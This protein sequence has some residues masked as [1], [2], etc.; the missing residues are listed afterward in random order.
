MWSQFL[1]Q[2]F[3]FSVNL[4]TALAF[5]SVFWLYFDAWVERKNLKEFLKILGFLLLSLS[6]LVHSTLIESSGFT[7]TVLGSNLGE[8][9]AV[10]LKC[11]GFAFL[12]SGLVYDPLI[13][14][15]KISAVFI[16]S[17]FLG[18][19]LTPILASIT[20]WLYLRRATI[21]LED[22]TKKV[23]LSIFI[24][25]L[26]ELLSTSA[27]FSNTNN[28]DIYRLVAPFGPIW[29]ISH[30]LL[31]LGSGILI[32][33]AFSYLLKRINTQLFIIFTT[34]TLAIF[35][36]TTVS[37]T[38]LLLKNLTEETLVRLNTDVSVLSF[39]LDAKKSEAHASAAIL[40]Q[41]QKVIDALPLK[42]KSILAPLAEELLVSRK[43]N[44]VIIVDESGQVVVRGEERDRVGDSLSNNP[45]VKRTLIGESVSSVTS[46]ENVLAPKI[47]VQSSSPIMVSGKVIGATIVALT[48]DNNFLDG[49][50]KL[51][52]LEVSVY[53]GDKLSATTI[54]DLSG[55]SRPIGIK[56]DNKTI[57]NTVLTLGNNYSGLVSLLNTSYFAVFHPLKDINNDSVGMLSAGRPAQSIYSTASKTIELTFLITIVL[58]ILSVFPSYYI[59]KYLS[60]QL[61]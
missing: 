25:A 24:L 59:A 8:T 61:T 11:L 35:L 40:S 60:N 38:F 15:P 46:Q 58:I 43:L 20:A 5:F 1:L 6:F 39:A 3:H 17:S 30:L 14:K 55:T 34:T 57:N 50:K 19:F 48:I 54:S 18:Y 27:L 51:T 49:I 47:L 45:I 29:I 16:A 52:G 12:I 37:F 36:I 44:S 33:W 31:L 4:F 7:T 28:I 9:I 53:G 26:H 42:D 22:H 32:Q 56:N 13:Q 2:N 41:N 21:G 10:L 23:S